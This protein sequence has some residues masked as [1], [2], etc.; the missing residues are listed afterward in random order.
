MTLH[1]ETM[2]TGWVRTGFQTCCVLHRKLFVICT[3]YRTCCTKRENNYGIYRHPFTIFH[4]FPSSRWRGFMKTSKNKN[5]YF[6]N[7]HKLLF[8]RLHSLTNFW[9]NSNK[10]A[11][12]PVQHFKTYLVKLV[13]IN[14]E[15]C[16]F[17]SDF[18]LRPTNK[19]MKHGARKP[20]NM[21]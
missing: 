11:A 19:I 1:K 2:W 16:D 5:D 6:G 10:D 3:K 13:C 21:S 4:I 17:L 8:Y 7:V 15:G 20:H 18:W 9:H 14:R 12:L